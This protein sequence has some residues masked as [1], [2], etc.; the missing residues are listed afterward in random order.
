MGNAPTAHET[1]DGSRGK[2]EVAQQPREDGSGA[3]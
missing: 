2:E 1:V 3:G